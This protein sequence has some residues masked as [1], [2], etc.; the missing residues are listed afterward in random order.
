[1]KTP[2]NTAALAVLVP[3]V[4]AIANGRAD[5]VSLATADGEDDKAEVGIVWRQCVPPAPSPYVPPVHADDPRF[6][7]DCGGEAQ[8]LAEGYFC[9]A[10]GTNWP[11]APA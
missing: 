9:T 8:H 5:V 1:M 7:R 11:D 3:L 6:C 4:D 2:N 10:C